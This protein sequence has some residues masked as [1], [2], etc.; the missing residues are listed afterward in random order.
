MWSRIGKGGRK[1]WGRG[2]AGIF[3]TDGDKV[4]LLKRSKKGDNC[5]SWGLPGGKIEEGESPIDAALREA[6]EECGKVLGQRFE[7]AKETDG[8]HEWTTF[9]FKV[10]RPFECELSDEHTDYKWADIKSLDKYEL[11]PKLKENLGRYLNLLKRSSRK[12]LVS[13]KEWMSFNP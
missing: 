1:Y 13:F 5:G 10:K 3:F 6:K 12:G 7:D 11:H 4:L 9:F 8:L 2:G